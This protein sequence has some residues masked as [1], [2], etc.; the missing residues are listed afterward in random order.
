METNKK[1]WLSVQVIYKHGAETK[2]VVARNWSWDT[3]R[4]F[5]ETVFIA[6][7][8]IPVFDSNNIDTGAFIIVSPWNIVSIDIQKQDSFFKDY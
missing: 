2:T 6:G 1:T 8:M 3:V 5:R 7:Y 4:Q